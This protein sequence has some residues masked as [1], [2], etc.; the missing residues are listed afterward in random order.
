M[1]EGTSVVLVEEVQYGPVGGFIYIS[2]SD[3]DWM[4]IPFL[5]FCFIFLLCLF[6]RPFGFVHRDGGLFEYT[7]GIAYRL[8]FYCRVSRSGC[9]ITYCV[10]SG[11]VILS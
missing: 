6:L 10:C 5:P 2:E 1:Q 7:P 4:Y 3:T 9:N 8:Y 11:K